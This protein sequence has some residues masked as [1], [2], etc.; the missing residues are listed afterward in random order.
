MKPSSTLSSKWEV[1]YDGHS[2]FDSFDRQKMIRVIS[3]E[4]N[5]IE[6]CRGWVSPALVIC[7]GARG[8]P[9]ALVSRRCQDFGP[10]LGKPFRPN[11]EAVRKAREFRQRI[12]PAR[13]SIPIQPD[14][15]FVQT[16]VDR[17]I[18]SLLPPILAARSTNS[19]FVSKHRVKVG[20]A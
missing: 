11:S 16:L 3:C 13:N 17:E 10:D 5:S 6:P 4:Q 15:N 20:C 8:R 19:T 14:S 9:S 12:E 18:D 1:Q 7:E 2:S